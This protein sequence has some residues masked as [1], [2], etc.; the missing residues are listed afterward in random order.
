M[1]QRLARISTRY[2]HGSAPLCAAEPATAT[3]TEQPPQIVFPRFA[4][5]WIYW[6]FF[7]LQLSVH[8]GIDRVLL[9]RGAM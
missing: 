3:A 5:I 4:H 7:R 1:V 8:W 2:T 9:V 6:R